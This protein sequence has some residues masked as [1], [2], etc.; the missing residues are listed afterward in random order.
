[1][2]SKTKDKL[3]LR[4]AYDVKTSLLK[5]RLNLDQTSHMTKRVN[6]QSSERQ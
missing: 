2:M 4:C 3:R 6:I 5:I 1:M